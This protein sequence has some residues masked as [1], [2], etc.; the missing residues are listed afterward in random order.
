MVV[1]GLGNL[2]KIADE[3]IK[4]R[5]CSVV[6]LSDVRSHSH[7]TLSVFACICL[8]HLHC[9]LEKDSIWSR[10]GHVHPT[11]SHLLSLPFLKAETLHVTGSCHMQPGPPSNIQTRKTWE[12]IGKVEDDKIP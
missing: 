10:S 4:K 9:Y 6:L 5:F 11:S 1:D 3:C 2:W 7:P 12:N 8:V